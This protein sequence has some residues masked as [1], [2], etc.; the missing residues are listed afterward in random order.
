MA[1]DSD[2]KTLHIP[3]SLWEQLVRSA[4][5]RE[6][7]PRSFALLALAEAVTDVDVGV[8]AR[9]CL[10][11]SPTPATPPSLP[12]RLTV[13]VGNVEHVITRRHFIIGRNENCHLRLDDDS[14]DLQHAIVEIIDSDA[15]LVDMGSASGTFFGSERIMRKAIADGDRFRI[16][17]TELSFRLR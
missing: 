16:G 4:Q 2:D 5:E 6:T 14:I 12:M 10:S 17:S 9:P 11:L 13:S 15:F 1:D 7:D 3:D 8:R